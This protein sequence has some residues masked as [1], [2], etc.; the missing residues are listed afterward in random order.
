MQKI[1]YLL[2]LTIGSIIGISSCEKCKDCGPADAPFVKFQFYNITLI[3]QIKEEIQ[4]LTTDINGKND[5][6]TNK[7][8]DFEAL[9]PLV[10]EL[11]KLKTEKNTALKKLNG[12]L[13]QMQSIKAISSEKSLD[14]TNDTLLYTLNLPLSLSSKVSDFVLNFKDGRKDT[15]LINYTTKQEVNNYQIRYEADS[16]KVFYN[17]CDSIRI[18]CKTKTYTCKPV[19]KGSPILDCQSA[20][21]NNNETTYKIYY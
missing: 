12:G 8:G 15:V 10:E 2:L 18:E 5:S 3:S 9:I 13:I 16:I 17:K 6:I 4:T 1:K 11:E 19:K 14:M 20:D 7:K 21:C